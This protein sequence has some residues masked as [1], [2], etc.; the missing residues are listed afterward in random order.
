[1]TCVIPLTDVEDSSL[2]GGKAAALS[3]LIASGFHVPESYGVTTDAYD[4]FAALPPVAR[5]LKQLVDRGPATAEQYRQIERSIDNNFLSTPVPPSIEREMT[6]AA[7]ALLSNAHAVVVRSSATT[8]DMA[9]AS[10]AGQY[11][12]FLN[13]RTPEAALDA[14]RLTWASLWYPSACLYREMHGMGAVTP[15]MGALLMPQIDARRAGVAFSLDTEGSDAVR[16]ETVSGLGEGLVSGRVTPEVEFVP[17][18]ARNSGSSSLAVEVAGQALRAESLFGVPQDIEWA[19]DG[20]SLWLVQSRP[21]TVAAERLDAEELPRSGDTHWTTAGV[22]EMLPGL[23]P[24]LMWSLNS[25]LVEE[26][27]RRLFDDLHSLPFDVVGSSGFLGHTRHRAVLNLDRLEAVAAAI[28]GGSSEEVERQYFGDGS[29]GPGH[30]G[31]APTHRPATLV[32]DL[33]AAAVRRRASVEAEIVASAVGRIADASVDLSV[34]NDHE[35]TAYW[36]RVIDLAGRTAAAEI[37][38]AAA[39]AA[40]Y[41]K[42]ESFLAPFVGTEEAARQAQLLTTTSQHIAPRAESS[43]SVFAGPTWAESEQRDLP[44]RFGLVAPALADRRGSARRDLEARLRSMPRWRRARMLTGQVVDVRLHLLRR[45]LAEA[46]DL[47]ASRE[48]AKASLLLVGGETRRL[49]MEMGRRLVDRACLQSASDVDFL[50]PVELSASL[51][52]RRVARSVVE[53]RQR[54]LAANAEDHLPRRFGGKRTDSTAAAGDE[55]SGT[56]HGW[57]AS[58]GHAHGRVRVMDSPSSAIRPGEV[59]VART[60]DASWL[61]VFLESDALIV[62]EGGPLSHAAVVAREL[63]KPAVVN[64][65]GIVERLRDREVAVDVDGD[66]G[67]ISISEPEPHE[68]LGLSMEPSTG[69]LD[70][71][72]EDRLAVFVPAVMGAG[73][74]FSLVIW[75]RDLLH[76]LLAGR[77]AA[78][79]IRNFGEFTAVA[80]VVGEDAVLAGAPRVGRRSAVVTGMTFTALS[81]YVFFGSALNYVRPGG[82]V[83]DIAWLLGVSVVIAAIFA[84]VAIGAFTTALAG[85][86]APMWAWGLLTFVPRVHQRERDRTL[87][88]GAGLAAVALVTV[89]ATLRRGRLNILE[90]DALAF[91]HSGIRSLEFT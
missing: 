49:H 60:T 44:N 69:V 9:G 57:A 45:S 65:P 62:E 28:P 71:F 27:F 25:F 8:E 74:V 35:L 82:Y 56:I 79:R 41:R 61:P 83:S 21:I 77:L 38:V 66:K 48:R 14:L 59:L 40:A 55:Q 84:M 7:A 52:G 86:R 72:A 89:L 3:R 15:S 78:Q 26:G 12:S 22:A 43:M 76:N 33:R 16:V 32:H 29:S 81:A 80:T 1:M 91:Q 50:W 34:M 6:E 30:D 47:L 68:A 36:C 24:P 73:M 90:S 11:R 39:A 5:F 37:A 70:D 46:A 13:L 18:S 58:P 75:I 53:M 4:V 20:Y 87:E 54:S 23:F 88:L 51:Q 67:I 63:G 42:V 31:H 85:G 19:H 17:R 64:V 2:V 10:F